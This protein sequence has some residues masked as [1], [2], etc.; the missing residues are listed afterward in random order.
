M[1]TDTSTDSTSGAASTPAPK[2]PSRFG[3]R[4]I[5]AL[6]VFVIAALLT[7]VALVGHWGHR[8]VIDSERYIETV[9]P[10]ISQPEV[11]ESLSAAITDA[12]VTQVDTTSQVN[13]LLDNLFPNSQF[14]DA[15]AAPIAAGI[16][17]LI[18]ELVTRFVASDAF[19][20]IWIK[21]NTAAQKSLVRL[22][23]GNPEGPVQLQG[24]NVVLDISSLLVEIQGYLVENGI[25]AAANITVP[26]TDRQIVL[27]TSPALSQIRLIYSLTSPILQWFPLVIVALFALAIGL[28][29]RRARMVVAVGIVLILSSGL[30][31]IAMSTGQ[32][33]FDNQ[34]AATP[35][36]PASN[37]FWQTLFVY[38]LA[39]IQ[40]VLVLG[41]AII[42]AG[43]F[44]G[45]T[46]WARQLR[47]HVVRGL[48]EIGDRLPGLQPARDAIG[49]HLDLVRWVI[50]AVVL[51][52]LMLFTSALSTSAVLW[53]VAL[54]AGLVTAAQLLS[55]VEPPAVDVEPTE[56]LVV[57]TVVVE[58]SPAGG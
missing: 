23:E 58:E 9:G 14:N 43:W 20:T 29:R 41:I 46:K 54:A 21:L 51:L 38:L 33:A 53:A 49:G 39:G 7:P 57:E 30:L 22:L 31:S 18:G 32:E 15:L 16:N 52:I 10:L 25:D 34:L 13:G 44:G 12:V 40:A 56:V 19:E 42:V 24:D 17:S 55:D 1:A 28:S 5:A 48:D 11:Q 26:Q 45:R 2:T 36:G 6:L 37:V 27:M 50:Y 47:G 35:F 3:V 4:A 8:T